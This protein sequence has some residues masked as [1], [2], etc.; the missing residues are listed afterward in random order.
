MQNTQPRLTRIQISLP[1][2]L[3]QQLREAARAEHRTTSQQV[4]YIFTRAMAPET[5]KVENVLPF[6]R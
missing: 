3:A 1:A 6:W 4:E 5:P 2:D